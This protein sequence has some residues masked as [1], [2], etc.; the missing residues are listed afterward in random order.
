[1]TA[2]TITRS[3]ALLAGAAV[4]VAACGGNAATTGPGGTTAPVVTPAPATPAPVT[5]GPAGT[6]NPDL[7]FDTSSFHAD[8]DL[9]ALFPKEVGGD[10][11]TVLSMSGADMMG[12][13]G[14]PE[15]E[16]MLTSLHKTP[17]DLTAAFG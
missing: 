4:L 2:R 3:L 1:M 16:A 17:A 13:G 5:Q 12:E 11:L 9:E 10:P 14:S 8:V 6:V 7:T 15:L